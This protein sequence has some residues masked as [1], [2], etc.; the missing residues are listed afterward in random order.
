MTDGILYHNQDSPKS[1]WEPCV[2]M[3]TLVDVV[4]LA[5]VAAA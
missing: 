2:L 1:S 4:Y 3:L 5:V